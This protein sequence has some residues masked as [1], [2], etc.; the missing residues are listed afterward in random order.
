[1]P[2]SPSSMEYT[3]R[4]SSASNRE[5]PVQSA[6]RYLTATEGELLQLMTRTNPYLAQAA[7]IGFIF[8]KVLLMPNDRDQLEVGCAYISDYCSQLERL[9]IAKDAGGREDIIRALGE[10]GKVPESY[11]EG[12]VKPTFEEIP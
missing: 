9:S 3:P 11:Y 1:M 6:F 5:A 4:T 7:Q 10:G 12:K 8:D 2:R